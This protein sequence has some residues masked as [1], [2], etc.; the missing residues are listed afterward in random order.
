MQTVI[1]VSYNI[2]LRFMSTVFLGGRSV[3]LD[4]GILALQLKLLEGIDLCF[5]LPVQPLQQLVELERKQV[6][7]LSALQ[8][9][10]LAVG[11]S[12]VDH[13]ALVV[14]LLSAL[15]RLENNG[16]IVA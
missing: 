2:L 6:R 9:A 8:P 16:S 3:D 15:G 11:G 1:I 4:I 10:T 14:P 5:N 13:H 12:V 7:V